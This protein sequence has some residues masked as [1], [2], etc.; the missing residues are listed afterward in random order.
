MVI[1]ELALLGKGLATA[2]LA[3]VKVAALTP[4]EEAAYLL[5][6]VPNWPA[7][8]GNGHIVPFWNELQAGAQAMGSHISALADSAVGALHGVSASSLGAVTVSASACGLM[9]YCGLVGGDR[10]EEEEEPARGLLSIVP[11]ALTI[12]GIADACMLGVLVGS[13][14]VPLAVPLRLWVLGGIA[15]SFPTTWLIH[16][17]VRQKGLRAGFLLESAAIGASLMWLSWGT[18]L[19]SIAPDL[20][21]TAPLLFWACFVQCIFSWTW[22]VISITVMVL[23]TVLSLLLSSK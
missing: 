11:T 7:V 5:A 9:R 21:Q 15:L 16:H 19:L 17:V 12:C 18:K 2:S 3:A 6:S 1:V 22:I 14:G 4:H 8:F 20:V 13:V 10:S 23:T